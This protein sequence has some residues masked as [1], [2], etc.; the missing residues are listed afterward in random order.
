MPDGLLVFEAAERGAHLAVCKAEELSR[1]AAA[2]HRLAPGSAAALAQALTG[3][4]LLAASDL[5]AKSEA[6]VDLELRCCGPLEGLLTDADA[7][8]AV[9]GLVRIGSLDRA[10]TP[11]GPGPADEAPEGRFDARPV[12]ASRHDERAGLLSILRAEPGSEGVH[13]TAFPFAGGDLGAALTL[14]LRSDRAAGGEMAL[15]TLYRQAEPL[16]AV[17]GVLLWSKERDPAAADGDLSTLGKPLRQRILRE[18]LRVDCNARELA[19]RIASGLAL[20]PLRAATGLRPRFSC[21]CSRP[22]VE[23]ALRAFGPAELRDMAFRD[24]GAEVL[25]DFCA[26]NWRLTREELLELAAAI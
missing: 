26:T 12:L 4:L 9:R 7:G 15:E 21:R 25:C 5:D 2:R 17:A 23:R 19:E 14:F 20:G 16:S 24:H 10:G 3:T 1:E 13:R 6:R 11:G 18:S 8:G 22:R